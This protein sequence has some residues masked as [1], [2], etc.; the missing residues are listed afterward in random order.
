MAKSRFKLD[1]S[2]KVSVVKVSSKILAKKEFFDIEDRE[3]LVEYIGMYERFGG[4][5]VLA[6]S[7]MPDSF[8]ILLKVPKRPLVRDLPDDEELVA[9]VRAGLGDVVADDLE[10]QLKDLR[11]MGGGP[12]SRGGKAVKALRER[13]LLR[14]WS[15]P[16]YM[17]TL[18]QRFTRWYNGRH[19]CSGTLWT[20]RYDGNLVE[21]TGRELR[22]MGR[23]IE[24]IPVEAGICD[25]SEDYRW[26]ACRKRF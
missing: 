15:F 7:V 13:W 12:R 4:L 6:Y 5:K 22:K 10:E 19:D 9:I 16:Y 11:S 24:Q 21:K 20:R 3:K 17:K 26:S 2:A 8:E 1:P 23:R 18:K 25:E 14:M